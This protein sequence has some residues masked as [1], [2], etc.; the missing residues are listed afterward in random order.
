MNQ[1]QVILIDAFDY[2]FQKLNIY[3][4]ITCTYLDESLKS[5]NNICVS[6]QRLY[7]LQRQFINY[8]GYETQAALQLDNKMQLE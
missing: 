8:S 7:N 1:K 5:E 3:K 6:S 4:E 2:G